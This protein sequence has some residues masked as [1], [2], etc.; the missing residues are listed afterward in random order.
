MPTTALSSHHMIR[1]LALAAALPLLATACD[2][3]SA[4]TAGWSGTID[5]LP[6][7]EIVVHNADDPLWTPE[8]AWRVTEE[9]RIGSPMSDGPDLFG[10]IQ[11]FDVDAWGRIFVLDDLAQEVRVFDSDGAFVRTVEGRGRGRASFSRPVR[12]TFRATARSG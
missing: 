7:G 9:L 11:S 4:A 12:S 6:S 10:A 2:T 3:G 5:T 8:T 1:R